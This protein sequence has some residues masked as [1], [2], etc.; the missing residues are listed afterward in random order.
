MAVKKAA[1]EKKSSKPYIR[2]EHDG[3][4]SGGKVKI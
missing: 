4:K 1:V 3:K 2:T